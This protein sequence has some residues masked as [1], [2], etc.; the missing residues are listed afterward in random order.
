MFRDCI[1][2]YLI[3]SG[4]DLEEV[5]NIIKN[6]RMVDDMYSQ[7]YDYLEYVRDNDLKGMIYED[8]DV[9]INLNKLQKD[10]SLVLVDSIKFPKD[11]YEQERFLVIARAENCFY[12]ELI[13]IIKNVNMPKRKVRV[14]YKFENIVIDF[15]KRVLKEQKKDSIFIISKSSK[16]QLDFNCD[17]FRKYLI[18]EDVHSNLIQ[19]SY[20]KENMYLIDD[21]K[22]ALEKYKEEISISILDDIFKKYRKV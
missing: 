10:Y 20:E 14:E 13:T 6:R 18:S 7:F 17:D 3:K 15:F 2:R 5:N 21:I 9:D 19:S 22:L 12:H 16:E 11:K 4:R 1:K 8:G